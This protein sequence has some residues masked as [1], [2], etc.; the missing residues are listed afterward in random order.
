MFTTSETKLEN[1]PRSVTECQRASR[2]FSSNVVT[3]VGRGCASL[4][5]S[6]P[7]SRVCLKIGGC[8]KVKKDLDNAHQSVREGGQ[9]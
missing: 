6:P 4:K 3:K 2:G 7:R 5:I 9:R 8:S 1:V